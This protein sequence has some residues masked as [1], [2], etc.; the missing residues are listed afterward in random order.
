MSRFSHQISFTTSAWQSLQQNPLDPFLS[1]RTPVEALGGT[2]LHAY[3]A[4]GSYDLLALTEFPEH[5]SHDDIAIAFYSYGAVA[6]VRS[7]QLLAAPQ[8]SATQPKPSPNP[9]DFGA[10]LPA[11]RAIAASSSR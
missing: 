10:R 4:D 2:L 6:I 5:I 3:F 9:Q 8:S 7:T 11:P 1:V